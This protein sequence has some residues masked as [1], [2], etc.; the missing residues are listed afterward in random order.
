VRLESRLEQELNQSSRALDQ[1][2]AG[3]QST[4]SQRASRREQAVLL[5]AALDRLPEHYREVLV[6]HHL[7]GRSLPEVAQRLGR[8]LNSVKNIWLR[9][10]AQLR[11]LVGGEP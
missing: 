3:A 6:L 4:P 1:R 2:L 5:A 10:L 7:E 9:A 11:S 8:S